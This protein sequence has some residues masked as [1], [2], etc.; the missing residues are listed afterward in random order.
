MYHIIARQTIQ[1]WLAGLG[2]LSLLLGL[3]AVSTWLPAA[4]PAT[5]ETGKVILP[6]I[7]YH[8]VLEDTARQGPYVISPALLENDLA[9]LKEQ[10][11]ET[12]VM[13]DLLDY[14]EKGAPLPEKPVLLTFDDGYYN[15]L[16]HAHPLLQKYGMQAVLSPVAAW[17]VFY[18]AHPEECDR[19]LYSHL[20]GEQ[21]RQMVQSGVWEIQNHSYDMHAADKG[22]RKGTTKL[23]AETEG[24]Y[25]T[26]LTEDLSA[27]QRWL[28]DAAGVAPT[29]FTY[30]FGAM[31]REALP[32]LQELGFRATLTCEGRLNTLTRDPACLWGLGR[33]LRPT[34]SSSKAYFDPILRAADAARE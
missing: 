26:T 16:A 27:A 33:Y 1:R 34:G 29:T 8:G 23:A 4:R 30:P 25:Q 19:V 5:A 3:T 10:G 2:I 14:V 24:Q 7:M 11:Y 6:I 22:K 31:S 9:Y 17:S 20:T 12:V 13:Q 28:T 32:V 18:T 21:L 15:N